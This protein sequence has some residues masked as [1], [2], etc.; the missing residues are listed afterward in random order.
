[1][2]DIVLAIFLFA[3]S[4]LVH[5]LYCRNT[6]SRGLHAKAFILIAMAGLLTYFLSTI[7]IA[8]TAGFDPR[9]LIGMPLELS[10]G[11]LFILL[12]PIY[13][14]FYV[15]TQLMSP[16]KKILLTVA[17]GGAISYAD[18]LAS[19]EEENFIKTRLDDLLTCGC[20]GQVDGRYVLTAEGRKI[21]AI[22]NAMQALLGRKPGG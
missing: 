9:S 19:I 4:V 12:I 2:L 16:S 21:A 11:I 20:V 18:I 7:A 14:C 8:K 17:K 15:L 13:L 3:A 22:L 6:N 1:M 10:S 5:L